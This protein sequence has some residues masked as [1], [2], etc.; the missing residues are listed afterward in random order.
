MTNLSPVAQ[1]CAA[2][3]SRRAW[4]LFKASKN[5]PKAHTP[6]Q[7]QNTPH[8][9]IPNSLF[10]IPYSLFPILLFNCSTVLSPQSPVYYHQQHQ[11][12]YP[13]KQ[14]SRRAR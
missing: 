4:R 11:P 5:I 13:Y 6:K 3:C 14:S 7:L 2:G 9:P 8:F 1:A 10:P 12:P